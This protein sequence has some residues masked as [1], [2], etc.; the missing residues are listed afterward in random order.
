MVE[1]PLEGQHLVARWGEES[2]RRPLRDPAGERL[3]GWLEGAA[4]SVAVAV[5][6]GA[7]PEGRQAAFADLFLE[8]DTT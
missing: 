8:A 5:Q 4:L 7:A 3:W 6:Q 1:G 2:P